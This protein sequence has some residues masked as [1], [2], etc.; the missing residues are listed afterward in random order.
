MRRGALRFGLLGSPR[1]EDFGLRARADQTGTRKPHGWRPYA[2]RVE[3]ASSATPCMCRRYALAWDTNGR[4]RWWPIPIGDESIGRGRMHY[5][6]DQS[7]SDSSSLIFFRI[8]SCPWH[9]SS[10]AHRPSGSARRP[11]CPGGRSRQ[12]P[13]E[14]Q[15]LQ[16]R[17]GRG[18]RSRSRALRRQPAE[19][20]PRLGRRG[21]LPRAGTG[22]LSG[23]RHSR[24]IRVTAQVSAGRTRP[25]EAPFIVSHRGRRHRVEFVSRCSALR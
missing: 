1:A 21:V 11:S 24:Q 19:L 13:L 12:Q 10:P 20:V 22:V 23:G 25:T 14:A 5:E 8:F 18:G 7:F 9:P 16:L 2:D 6:G 15:P 3:S 4:R 17:R